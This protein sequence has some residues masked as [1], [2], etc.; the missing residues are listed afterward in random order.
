[1]VRCKK[2]PLPKWHKVLWKTR[3]GKGT[4]QHNTQA[5]RITDR[6][7]SGFELVTPVTI[8]QQYHCSKATLLENKK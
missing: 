3:N 5:S 2:T 4:G 1:M 7:F 6:L 8:E